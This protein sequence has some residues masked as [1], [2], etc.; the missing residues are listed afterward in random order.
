[1]PMHYKLNET[2][3][4]NQSKHEYRSKDFANCIMISK[5]KRNRHIDKRDNDSSNSDFN[6]T[7]K[8]QVFTLTVVKTKTK[9]NVQM[10]QK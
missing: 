9:V 4:H 7:S 3:L 5:S 1:M 8:D 10:S 6:A 2:K